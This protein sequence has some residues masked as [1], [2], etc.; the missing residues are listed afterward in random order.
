MTLNFKHSNAH[1]RHTPISIHYN[2]VL[3]VQHHTLHVLP[4]TVKLV[5]ET[6]ARARKE[7]YAM[8]QPINTLPTNAE[9]LG[10]VHACE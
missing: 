1:A 8:L 2:F 4:N 3:L 10:G 6:A 7:K 5:A 9:I